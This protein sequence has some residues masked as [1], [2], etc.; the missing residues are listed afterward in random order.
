MPTL[1]RRVSFSN[2]VF[3]SDDASESTVSTDDDLSLLSS[4]V[5]SLGGDS[6]N[7][8]NDAIVVDKVETKDTEESV[9][10][11][12]ADDE[13]LKEAPKTETEED[14]VL[15]GDEKEEES[16]TSTTSWRSLV[17]D[18]PPL[19]FRDNGVVRRP[20][21]YLGGCSE[22]VPAQKIKLRKSWLLNGTETEEHNEFEEWKK[23]RVATKPVEQT[24]AKKSDSL[25]ES[26]NN[27]AISHSLS[28]SKSNDD[29]ED[30]VQKGS[31][32]KMIDV[33]AAIMA[34]EEV[35]TPNPSNTGS[36]ADKGKSALT[37]KGKSADDM[38]KSAPKSEPLAKSA[39][40]KSK[41]ARNKVSAKRD[42]EM[43]AHEKEVLKM[44]EHIAKLQRKL[45]VVEVRTISELADLEEET[46]KRMREFR[47]KANIIARKK[48]AQEERNDLKQQAMKSQDLIEH[49]RRSN[50]KLRSQ[51]TKLQGVV[52]KLKKSN[53]SLE[54]KNAFHRDY[55]IE[56]LN[57]QKIEVGLAE[58]MNLALKKDM[59]KYESLVRGMEEGTIE[60][61][62][63]GHIERRSKEM[64]EDCTQSLLVMM[65]E[66]CSDIG[67]VEKLV[68][69]AE[70]SDAESET[71]AIGESEDDSPAAYTER[72]RLN[73]RP[74]SKTGSMVAR[75]SPSKLLRR[76]SSGGYHGQ[77]GGNGRE[78]A[79]MD[80]SSPRK[81][82]SFRG[83]RSPRSVVTNSK[84][85]SDDDSSTCS[86]TSVQSDT[87]SL[88]G[89][90]L[91]NY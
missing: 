90:I 22:E 87:V 58:Q 78:S 11:V 33:E 73:T 7:A 45:D 89:Y 23:S 8:F 48:R 49:L 72:R 14:L 71:P 41:V 47:E 19:I 56:F 21:E 27:L 20:N 25:G 37:N 34:T 46:T 10:T 30:I 85:S 63:C 50:Q 28:A 65:D 84:G 13:E 53:Q 76:S 35:A 62:K 70:G 9:A 26:G 39:A 79:E 31:D 2:R 24:L 38:K 88:G 5:G 67:L 61:E 66:Y 16:S 55:A 64:Y 57:F 51:G 40:S 91:D 59:P 60:R 4:D 82:S 86:I 15:H 75:P 32:D 52:A 83:N 36:P 81:P 74:Y 68:S 43:E 17:K 6:P 3:Y 69:L 42:K 12:E 54:E 44:K 77:R 1:A 29:M 18:E 80:Y